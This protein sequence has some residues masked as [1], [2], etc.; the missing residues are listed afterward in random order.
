M[1]IS[2]SDHNIVVVPLV[3]D[4]RATINPLSTPIK[5][6]ECRRDCCISPETATFRIKHEIETVMCLDCA[7]VRVKAARSVGVQYAVED[8]V[9]IDDNPPN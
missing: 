9:E 8:G 4:P 6:S 3:N 5:C 2:K 1:P 7:M